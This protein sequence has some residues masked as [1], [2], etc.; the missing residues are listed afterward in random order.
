MARLERR[1]YV[2]RWS[3]RQRD[4]VVIADRAGRVVASFPVPRDCDQP[5]WKM[6][7]ETGWSAFPGAEWQEQSEGVW[8]V[9]V[10]SQEL[11]RR[12]TDGEG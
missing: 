12:E 9:A 8:S 1:D 3:C 7:L 2:A 5:S 10:F 6:L 11:L 4:V